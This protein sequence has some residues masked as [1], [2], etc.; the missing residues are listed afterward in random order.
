MNEGIFNI[1][2]APQLDS[3]GRIEELRPRELLKDVAG[4]TEGMTC[5]DF[6]SGT[7]AFALPMVNLVGN[8]GRVYAVD[9]SAEMHDHLKAKPPP[10]NLVMIERDVQRTGLDDRIA[11]ICFMAFILVFD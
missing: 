5:V 3:P 11:D 4:V 1:K 2:K 9:N 8:E 6:G 7:G 10:P